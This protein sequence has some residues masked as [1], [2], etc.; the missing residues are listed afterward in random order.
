MKQN[1]A[2]VGDELGCN[3][4]DVEGGKKTAAFLA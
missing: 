4:K 1:D 2:D 3:V